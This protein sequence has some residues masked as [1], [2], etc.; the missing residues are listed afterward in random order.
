MLCAAGQVGVDLSSDIE[1][2]CKWTYRY[3]AVWDFSQREPLFDDL[4]FSWVVFRGDD[5]IG[6]AIILLADRGNPIP[7]WDYC[8][9]G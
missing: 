2:R 1:R 6:G 5:G 9:A 8:Q 7:R 4:V 3:K